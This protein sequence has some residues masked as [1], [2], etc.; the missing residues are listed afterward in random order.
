MVAMA[1]YCDGGG[2]AYAAVDDGY[3][4]ESFDDAGAETLATST[5]ATTAEE[6]DATDAERSLVQSGSPLTFAQEGLPASPGLVIIKAGPLVL[7]LRV[8]VWGK[9]YGRS[10]AAAPRP[11]AKRRCRD[12]FVDVPRKAVGRIPD[13]ADAG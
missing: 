5:A 13:H 12:L 9:R 7:R 6:P 8:D 2:D 11:D 1:G 3:G 4:E 10:Y